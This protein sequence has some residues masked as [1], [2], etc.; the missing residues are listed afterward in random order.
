MRC[1]KRILPIVALLYAQ[2]ELHAFKQPGLRS[3]KSNK[4]KQL[5][6][7]GQLE[8]NVITNLSF[9]KA[10]QLRVFLKSDQA[11]ELFDKQPISK[12]NSF[13]DKLRSL[14]KGA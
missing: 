3:A 5:K 6:E 8:K 4:S 9:E 13:R 1:L 11:R 10:N 12:K 14:A 7:S 2:V